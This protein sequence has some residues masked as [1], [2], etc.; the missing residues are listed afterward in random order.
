MAGTKLNNF[1]ELEELQI[2]EH[3]EQRPDVSPKI[4]TGVM[5]NM[6]TIGFMGDILELYLPR[7]A[8]ILVN[9]FGGQRGNTISQ[10]ESSGFT[11]GDQKPD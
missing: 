8:E 9:I 7:V 1:Q 11:E 6:R 4:E 5:A 10:G 2:N 3:L